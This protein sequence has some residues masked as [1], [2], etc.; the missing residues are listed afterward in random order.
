MEPRDNRPEARIRRLI[1]A[2][3]EDPSR[4]W[5]LEL[6]A[7]EAAMSGRTLVR[8]FIAQTGLTPSKFIQRARVELA[9]R[10]IDTAAD[11]TSRLARRTGF[12]NPERMRRT[13]KRV[14]GATPTH[15][16]TQASLAIAAMLASVA[17]PAAAAGASQ[18]APRRIDDPAITAWMLP[19]MPPSPGDNLWSEER[20]QLGAML[21]FDARLSY[22]GQ[23]S[24]GWCHSPERGWSD[25]MQ[26]AVR[27]PGNPGPVGS[28]GL[29]NVGY[30]TIFMW[31][32][33]QPSLEA[34]ALGTLGPTSDVNVGARGKTE[35]VVHRIAALSGYRS[36]FEAAYPGE[37]ITAQTIAKALASFQRSIVS[38]NSPFDRWIAGE[39]HA[40]TAQQVNGFRIFTDP[41]RGGCSVCH[42][43][44]NFTD[45]G[46][47]NIGLKSYGEGSPNPGRGKQRPIRVMHGAFKTPALRDVALSAPYFHDG[48]A[49]TLAD[50][51]EHYAKGGEVTLN[52]SPSFR[53]APL[54]AQ[55]KADLV[56]FLQALTTPPKPFAYPVLPH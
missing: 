26:T 21:F 1:D 44:P 5:P 23:V 38:R 56:A 13:F 34:Q 36:A 53:K 25:G 20:S 8:R 39:S 18:Q 32:G 11:G 45:N 14:L 41:S 3:L 43:P 10:M 24:C 33:R 16:R 52:L 7:S 30:N 17:L 29:A 46:F 50:V 48:S 19:P 6:L 35:D 15:C 49:A 37:G 55:D 2:I 31:D 54:S 9:L 47:H 22:S 27:F 42:Q 28:P 12:G 40:M 51:V 4:P